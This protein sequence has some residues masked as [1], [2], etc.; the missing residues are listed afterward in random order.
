MGKKT[1]RVILT[2]DIDGSADG[3]AINSVVRN[4]DGWTLDSVK[5]PAKPSISKKGSQWERDFAKQLSKWWSDGKDEY[6]FSRRSGSGGSKR[7][8]NGWSEAS[9]DIH[10]DKPEGMPLISTFSFECKFI[11]D[12]TAN[13]W[14][15]FTGQVDRELLAFWQQ[16]VNSAAPYPLR[17]L[18]LVIKTNNRK[19]ICITNALFIKE[20]VQVY[21]VFEL[22]GVSVVSFPLGEFFC[23]VLPLHIMDFHSRSTKP[24]PRIKFVR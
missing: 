2:V 15:A 6:I 4:I 23:R 24:K 5:R 21:S 20:R 14:K 7:D 18:M 12:F 9:G 13:Y 8:Q 22:G 3:A 19:P 17:K 11:Q 1:S 10:L 16:T